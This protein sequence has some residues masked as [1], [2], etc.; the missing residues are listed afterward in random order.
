MKAEMHLQAALCGEMFI[1]DWTSELLDSCVGFSVSCQCALHSKCTETLCTFVRLLMSV[2]TDVS[3]QV[4][5]LLKLLTAIRAL[6]PANTIH[7]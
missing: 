7:L 3:Y 1:T 5:G 4:T 2:D 6:V